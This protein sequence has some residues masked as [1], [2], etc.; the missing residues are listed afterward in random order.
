MVIHI[1]QFYQIP[2]SMVQFL[3]PYRRIHVIL[4][5]G[6]SNMWLLPHMRTTYVP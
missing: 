2:Q 6:W 5:A 4:S 1:H 3:T